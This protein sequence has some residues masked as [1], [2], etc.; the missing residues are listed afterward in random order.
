VPQ[1]LELRRSASGQRG[2]DD[3]KRGKGE[4]VLACKTE[5]ITDNIDDATYRAWKISDYCNQNDKNEKTDGKSLRVYFEV[6][7]SYEREDLKF[8]E[9]QLKVLGEIRNNIG[10]AAAKI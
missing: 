8:E 5:L 3:N 6:L 10:G 7:E 9:K 4:K 1:N 2:D